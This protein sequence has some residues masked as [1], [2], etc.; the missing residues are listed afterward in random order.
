[1]C[2]NT[3]YTHK[4][5]ICTHMCA[6]MTYICMNLYTYACAHM[7]MSLSKLQET[8]KD[9]GAWHDTVYGVTKS[10]TRLSN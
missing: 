2:V 5:N 6:Q 7:N 3:Q 10:Q 8:V 4:H 9:R 1:M